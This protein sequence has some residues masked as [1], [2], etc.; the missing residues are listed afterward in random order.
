MNIEFSKAE[1]LSIEDWAE[2]YVACG[3]GPNFPADSI[4]TFLAEEI[5]RKCEAAMGVQE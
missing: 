2:N 3:F 4:G 5:I 1:L